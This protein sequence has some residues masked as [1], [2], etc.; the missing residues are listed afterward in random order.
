MSAQIFERWAD[1]LVQEGIISREDAGLYSYGLEQGLLLALNIGTAL[2]IG[3]LLDEFVA[4]VIFL[5]CFL[6]LRAMAG[7]YHART[8]FRCYLLGMVMV[9]GVL[10]MIKWFPWTMSEALIAVGIASI[11]I[12]LLAPV[13]NENKLLDVEEKA[14]YQKKT[15]VLLVSIWI[16]LVEVFMQK[17]VQGSSALDMSI[18]VTAVMLVLGNIKRRIL[19]RI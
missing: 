6:P 19:K 12:W 16:L 13:E 1:S 18:I 14:E 10:A 8:P 9:T 4:C 3:L 11:V 2:L 15:R 7:G 5:A 17:N